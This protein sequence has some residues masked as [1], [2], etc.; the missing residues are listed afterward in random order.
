MVS[1]EICEAQGRRP[2]AR[3]RRTRMKGAMQA[4][5]LRQL[6]NLHLCTGVDQR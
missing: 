5:T 6:G 1:R 3:E 4:I 2:G